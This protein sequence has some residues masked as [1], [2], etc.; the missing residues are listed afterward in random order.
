MEGE[1][2]GGLAALAPRPRL[3]GKGKGEDELPGFVGD[4]WF[5]RDT[6]GCLRV[7]LKAL[8]SRVLMGFA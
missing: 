6:R 8:R 3:R 2:R 1:F 4:S 5:P 7:F